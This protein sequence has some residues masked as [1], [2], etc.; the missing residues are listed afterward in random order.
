MP[1]QQYGDLR[2]IWITD[3]GCYIDEIKVSDYTIKSLQLDTLNY[4][5]FKIGVKPDARY[6]GGFN[7]FGEKF[8]DYSQNIIMEIYNELEDHGTEPDEETPPVSN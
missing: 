3:N 4:I 1:E 2:K 6:V 7:L 8:G 5:S